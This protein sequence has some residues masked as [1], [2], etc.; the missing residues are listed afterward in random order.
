MQCCMPSSAIHVPADFLGC[1]CW[2]AD[3]TSV[4]HW[5]ACCVPG[6][7]R[8]GECA[9]LGVLFSCSAAPGHELWYPFFL[10]AVSVRGRDGGRFSG[11]AANG[12]EP[13][14]REASVQNALSTQIRSA[15]L[16][17]TDPS[18]GCCFSRP[19]STQPNAYPGFSLL[20]TCQKLY[21]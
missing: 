10:G 17:S 11:F 5:L 4:P 16:Q 6:W 20:S 15:K 13:T 18:D 2:S 21:G 1:D 3:W 12:A 9:G 19:R 7:C 14:E 8:A